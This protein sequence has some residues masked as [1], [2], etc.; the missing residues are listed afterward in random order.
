MSNEG[1]PEP[2]SAGY[3]KPPP[4]HKFKKGRSGNPRGRPRKRPPAQGDMILDSYFG[5]IVLFE[6]LRPVQVKEGDKVVELTMI[7]AVIRSLSVSALKGDRKAQIT[8]ANMFK[9]AQDGTLEKRGQIYR[10]A[11]EYKDHWR[12]EFEA[13]DRNGLARPDPVPHPDD[14]S[15]D[16]QTLEVRVNGPES[17]DQKAEWDRLLARKQAFAEELKDWKRDIEADPELA[18]LAQVEIAYADYVYRSIDQTI[19]DEATRR[20]PGFDLDEWRRKKFDKTLKPPR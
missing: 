12:Q 2:R 3:G 10:A 5:D 7:Q 14:I 9:G 15:I 20:R 16:Q 17:H 18:E 11:T 1:K 6:A 8:I 13:C 4:E 19:P